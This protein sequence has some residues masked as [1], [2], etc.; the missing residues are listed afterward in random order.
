MNQRLLRNR[1]GSGRCSLSRLLA[2]KITK[3]IRSCKPASLN[4]L[5]WC[6]VPSTAI[7]PRETCIQLIRSLHADS[8]E[9]Y[10]RQNKQGRWHLLQCYRVDKGAG[11]VT[12]VD[13]NTCQS[14]FFSSRAFKFFV[15]FSFTPHSFF[16]RK[17]IFGD[18]KF[19]IKVS[20]H[21]SSI[22]IS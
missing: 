2:R 4:C 9:F 15:T 21:V 14:S 17:L 12:T 8:C 20:M 16:F 5:I 22:K 6:H 19:N 18:I 1:P 3:G 10:P 7:H 11:T 13:K